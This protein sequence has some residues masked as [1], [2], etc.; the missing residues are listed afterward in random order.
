MSTIEEIRQLRYGW[1]DHGVAHVERRVH[2]LGAGHVID[3]LVAELCLNLD[4]ACL[5]LRPVPHGRVRHYFPDG[6]P[7]PSYSTSVG[8]CAVAL[9]KYAMTVYAPGADM[10]GSRRDCWTARCESTPAAGS[11][12]YTC[13]T[14]AHS[15]PLAVCRCAVLAVI[16]STE[17]E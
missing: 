16:L 8:D 12:P 14:R 7:L 13:L 4:T 3:A 9:E 17:A 1:K 10:P 5:Q 2:D 15:M 11:L 6:T